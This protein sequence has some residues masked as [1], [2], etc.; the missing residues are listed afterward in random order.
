MQRGRILK[1]VFCV[2]AQAAG[3]AI[4]IVASAQPA[5]SAGS[6][7]TKPAEK[8]AAIALDPKLA[9]YKPVAN[10]S[11][12]FKS[13]GSDTMNNLMTF[14]SEGFLKLYPSVQVEIEGKGSGTAPPALIAG[15]SSFGPMSRAMKAKEIDEFEAKFGYK[16]V[17]VPTA[18]DALAVFV[19][20][21]N[22][23]R[24]LS[25]AQIDAIFS[26]TR[27]LGHASDIKT[28]G[29]LGLTGEWADKPISLYGRNAASGTY[30]F[31]KDHAMGGGD[32]KDS[33]KEQPGSASVIQGVA[34]DRYGIGYSGIG[35]ATA[36]VKAVPL[37]AKADAKFIPAASEFVYSGEYPLARS[38]W[39]YV[40][41]APNSKLDPLRAEF[42]RF[43]LSRPGQQ[44]VI[45]DG[46]YPVTAKMA[47]K[48]LTQLGLGDKTDK[49]DASAS[50]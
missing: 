19:H 37:A 33:V 30:G 47:E 17:G 29:D 25:L 4:A 5:A 46:F 32:Y 49:P 10:V 27:K 35:Y 31:L 48:A 18:L 20:K 45:K 15:T 28:W 8:A 23:I 9:E 22:P 41:Y 38:L 13:V 11:G 6:A 39:I 34:N 14:W 26:K 50:H 2:A 44:I 1:V 16:P 7:T 12:S 36:D 3:L 21:D 43:V 40:N 42:M 24:G